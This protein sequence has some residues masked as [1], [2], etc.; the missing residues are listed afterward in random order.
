M[1][2]LLIKNTYKRMPN[3]GFSYDLLV[4]CCIILHLS[5]IAKL[6]Q[7]IFTSVNSVIHTNE[8]GMVNSYMYCWVYK[9]MIRMYIGN[10]QTSMHGFICAHFLTEL[11]PV[12]EDH[13]S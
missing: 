11:P 2:V 7:A 10:K 9:F 3:K 5:I 12:I 8:R 6:H 13:T 4:I 1:S